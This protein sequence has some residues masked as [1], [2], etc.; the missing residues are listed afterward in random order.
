MDELKSLLDGMGKSI[1]VRNITPVPVVEVT[2]E[3]AFVHA[4]EVPDWFEVP[5]VEPKSDNDEDMLEADRQTELNRFWSWRIHF[6]N[7]LFSDQ[8]QQAFER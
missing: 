4:P 3:Y 8:I 1:P 7:M 2:S 6:A 5:E